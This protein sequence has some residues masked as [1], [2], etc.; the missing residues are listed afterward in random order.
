MKIE[1]LKKRLNKKR[2][3][4]EVTLQIPRDVVEDLKRV[5]LKLGFSAYQPLI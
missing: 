4:T 5:A 3:M 1:V 2:P